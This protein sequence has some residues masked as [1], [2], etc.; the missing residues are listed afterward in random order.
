[1]P[2]NSIEIEGLDEVQAVLQRLRNFGTNVRPLLA[3]AG[4]IIAN[5]TEQAF[6]DEGPG[7]RPLAVRTYHMSYRGKTHTQ[8]GKVTR[9]FERYLANRAILQKSGRLRN[10]ITVRATNTEVTVGTNL[11]YAAIHQFG[12]KAGRGRKVKIAARPYLP[13]AGNTLRGDVLAE[14][15]NYIADKAVEVFE[16]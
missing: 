5:A 2:G 9:G 8:R 3:E 15:T 14:I 6:E 16:K 13:I 12:G 4:N 10:S 11:P 7:W 1:M